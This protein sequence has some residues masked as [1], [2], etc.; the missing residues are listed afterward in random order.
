MR[1]KYWLILFLLVLFASGA[2]FVI[3]YNEIKN[4]AI[5]RLNNRQLVIAEQTRKAIE[6]FFSFHINILYKNAID[7]NIIE[8][9]KEGKI[10][11]ALLYN[12]FAD[13]VASVSRVDEKGFI[14]HTVPFDLKSINRDISYQ[15][16]IKEIMRTR[17]PVM[18]DVFTAVQGFRA[19]AL[20]VPVFKGDTFKGTIG[21]L[22]RFEGIAKRYLESIRIG[23]NGYAW[24]ISRDGVELY[25]PVPGHTG[26]TVFENCKDFPSIIN[27][28]REMVQGKS[29][30]TTYQYNMIRGSTVQTETKHAVYMPIKTVN[31]FW[32]IVVATPD[33][34]VLGAIGKFRT[35][36]IIIFGVILLVGIPTS[37]FGARAW[38]ILS[39]ETKRKEAERAL[40]ESEESYRALFDSSVDS[41]T[42]LTPEGAAIDMN[43]SAVRLFGAQSKEEML[44]LTP[45]DVSPEYQPDGS[46][47][48]V[49]AKEMIGIALE[50]DSH[51][52]EWVNKRVD[53]T[54]FLSTI[55]LSKM[56]FNGQLALQTSIRDITE[57]RRIWN[58]RFETEKKIIHS[59]KLESLGMLAGGLA[60]DFNNMLTIIQTN[61]EIALMELREDPPGAVSY[62]NSA[63]E[64]SRRV[65]EVTSQ[66]LA[67]AGKSVI[68]IREPINL[69]N[70]VQTSIVLC[71]ASIPDN[72]ALRFEG[73]RELPSVAADAG[74]IKQAVINLI[75]NS[76]EAIG[77]ND[78]SITVTT[79]IGDYDEQI[80]LK[81]RV[82]EKPAP[83]RFVFVEI[84][85]TGCGM[86]EEAQRLL[87][88][89]FFTTKFIG[90]GL[91]M[92]AILGIVRA[93]HG[94]IFVESAMSKGTTIRVILPVN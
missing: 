94:A 84:A 9:S 28:A 48:S 2:L 43:P 67:Y 29:G 26:K 11:M 56:V 8:L 73:G 6:G 44:Q 59:Q 87:F 33:S 64:A 51:F 13:N 46:L 88:E 83:G 69:N 25:C 39:E 30:T 23:D 80:L 34:E 85:D 70:I 31:T 12:S 75:N 62:I 57:E 52:F 45:A 3:F 77:T 41:I 89:P 68:S 18:S 91:G 82:D 20:H 4:D 27:M 37:Y 92:P 40:S 55:L 1:Y 7:R 38:G 5:E 90:R 60:H 16:H 24:L 65:A 76:S 14:I 58:E 19:I 61:L 21:F 15:P 49:K 53:G 86:D 63:M 17:R 74:Q 35:K 10:N 22:I 42:I 72:V 47:S 79:G 50:K 93:H 54:E 81:S 66:M 32:S 71:N 36:L 78:G